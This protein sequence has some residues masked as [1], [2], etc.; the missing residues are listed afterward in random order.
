MVEGWTDSSQTF[1]SRIQSVD[2]RINIRAI[3]DDEPGEIEGFVLQVTNVTYSVSGES[4]DVVVANNLTVTIEENDGKFPE[5][6]F[7]SYI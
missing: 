1:S 4:R 7:F 3:D 6:L 5:S 2:F